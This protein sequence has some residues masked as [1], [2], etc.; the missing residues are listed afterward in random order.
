[1]K[2][3]MFYVGGDVAGSNV[4]LHDV[5]F[6]IGE[7]DE[8]CRDDLRRQWWG[9]PR[10]L[11][12]DCWGAVEQVD[13]FDVSIAPA[14]TV[15][16]TTDRLYFV[17]LGGY[18]PTEFRELHENVLV[19]APD[20]AGAKAAALSRLA[21]WRL[22]HKDNLIEVDKTTDVGASLGRLGLTIVLT[23]ASDVKPFVFTCDYVP[24]G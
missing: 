5:R 2:L 14:G 9:D 20:A 19:V 24:I 23:R 8:A 15:S 16:E 3:F 21:G 18:S 4:E 1:M 13:G 22:P 10:S 17:N 12:L 11:H 6:S 7:T